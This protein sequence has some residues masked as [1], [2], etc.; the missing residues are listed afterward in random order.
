MDVIDS[1]G[2]NR[3][4]WQMT[5]DKIACPTEQHSLSADDRGLAS[6]PETDIELC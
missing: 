1:F 3:C 6:R 2:E 5:G 4:D